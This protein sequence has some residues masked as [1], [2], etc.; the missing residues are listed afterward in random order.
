MHKFYLKISTVF[1]LT[2]S[3]VACETPTNSTSTPTSAIKLVRQHT[4][5][6]VW[7]RMSDNFTIQAQHTNP[8]VKRFITQFTKNEAENLIK[9]SEQA[10]PYIYHIVTTLEQR[11]MPSE[12]ALLPIVESEYRPFATSKMGASGLWQL[13]TIT[14]RLYGLKQDGWADERKDVEI[15]TKVA[16]DHLQ[17]LVDKFNGDWLLAL[18]AYNAG[19]GRVEQ[20]I[21][22]NKKL[23]KPTDYWSLSL[24]QETMYFVPKFL[25]LVHIVQ[26]HHKL[27]VRLAPIENKPYFTTVNLTKQ[28]DINKAATMA[29]LDIKEVKSLNPALR[30]NVTHP[31]GP[32]KIVLPIKNAY[33]FRANY[34]AD[35]KAKPKASSKTNK[36]TSVAVSHTVHRGDTLF[37]IA[38]KYNTTVKQIKHKNNLTSDIIRSGQQLTI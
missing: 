20:A 32:H 12:L 29:K 28:L 6:T 36:A 13:A 7:D 8:R 10:S 5:K 27:D 33:I 23:G 11:G 17:Y 21:R 16:L 1:I 15:A 26:N 38:T 18:A 34:V 9:F 37:G 4:A 31:K 30:T 35:A 3:L 14:A 19:P 2:L 24:P 22:H 25:A